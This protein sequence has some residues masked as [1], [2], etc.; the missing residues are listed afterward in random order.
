MRDGNGIRLEVLDYLSNSE[1]SDPPGDDPQPLPFDK[2]LSDGGM[3]LRQAKVRL[4]VD[5][6]SD[7][8]WIP[9]V[10]FDPRE[11]VE[12]HGVKGEEALRR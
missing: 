10:T 4:T 2:D 3:R 6:H 9:C 11:M 8:F 7:E 5:G 12:L 1:P